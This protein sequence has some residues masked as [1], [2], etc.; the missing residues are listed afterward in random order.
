MTFDKALMYFNAYALGVLTGLLL[1]IAM[2][3]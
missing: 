3:C 1:A 2:H